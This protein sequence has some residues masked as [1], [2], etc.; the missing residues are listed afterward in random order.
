MRKVSD[1]GGRLEYR[2]GAPFALVLMLAAPLGFALNYAADA[3]WPAYMAATLSGIVG[4]LLGAFGERLIIDADMRTIHWSKTLLGRVRCAQTIPFARVTRIAVLA[5]RARAQRH[6]GPQRRFRVSIEWQTAAGEGDIPV[7]SFADPS[8][9]A[10]EA[11]TLARRLAAR[12]EHVGTWA[13]G[14]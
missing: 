13:A 4:F 3:E 7:A 5:H 11:E 8:R 2:K 12:V 9:A 6:R 14:S 10:D 1:S